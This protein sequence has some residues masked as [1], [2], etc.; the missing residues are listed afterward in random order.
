MPLFDGD[1]IYQQSN[2]PSEIGSHASPLLVLPGVR[3]MLQCLPAIDDLEPETDVDDAVAHIYKCSTF[4]DESWYNKKIQCTT[5][6][7]F[8]LFLD[9]ARSVLDYGRQRKT[10]TYGQ[11][12]VLV[13]HILDIGCN[14]VGYAQR[15]SLA[16]TEPPADRES[17]EEERSGFDEPTVEKDQHIAGDEEGAD[18]SGCCDDANKGK[19]RAISPPPAP[20]APPAHAPGTV[21]TPRVY[22]P[23]IKNCPY[24]FVPRGWRPDGETPRPPRPAI[25]GPPLYS[26][27]WCAE[28][29]I[30]IR[31]KS[32]PDSD[33]GTASASPASQDGCTSSGPSAA[34]SSSRPST[35]GPPPQRRRLMPVLV[36]ASHESLRAARGPFASELS[37]FTFSDSEEDEDEEEPVIT[38]TATASITSSSGLKS[39]VRRPH[40]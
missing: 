8:V 19:Q 13:R 25:E 15:C 9:W 18:E 32:D 28:R 2:T 3:S 10:L 38:A 11:Y 33:A 23:K 17:S 30:K 6:V 16:Q 21:K 31:R 35:D 24:P 14:D 1:D 20:P 29:N 26:E 39:N 5:E 12:A 7:R 27:A 37:D 34:A 22:Y 40:W 36:P 4:L